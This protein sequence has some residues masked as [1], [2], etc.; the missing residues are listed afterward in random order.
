MT[1]PPSAAAQPVVDHDDSAHR[2][3]IRVG[4]A[5]AGFTAYLDRGTERVFYHTAL[6]DAFAG[7]GLGTVLIDR[8]LRDTREAGRRIVPVCRFVTHYLSTHH[9]FDD[10]VD[11]PTPADLA[12]LADRLG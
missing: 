4:G 10:I 11:R 7:R 9:G 5:P 2:Y 6:D 12:W 1:D 3:V 8:A